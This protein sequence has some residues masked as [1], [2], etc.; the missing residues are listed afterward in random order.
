MEMTIVWWEQIQT[1]F[2]TQIHEAF[3]KSMRLF[4]GTPLDLK[5]LFDGTRP[6]YELFLDAVASLVITV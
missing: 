2:I 3:L 1:I 4:S 5:N 6:A